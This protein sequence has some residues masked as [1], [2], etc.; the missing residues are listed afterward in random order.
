MFLQGLLIFI[1]LR[2]LSVFSTPFMDP[3]GGKLAD[4]HTH[5][6]LWNFPTVILNSFLTSQ[7]AFKIIKVIINLSIGYAFN[8]QQKQ[9][10]D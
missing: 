1:R 3:F 4:D 6:P 7:K 10:H 5:P 8:E 2:H 9:E